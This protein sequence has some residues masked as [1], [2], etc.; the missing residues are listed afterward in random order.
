MQT[1]PHSPVG[2]GIEAGLREPSEALGHEEQHVVSNGLGSPDTRIEIG[3]ETKLAPRDTVLLGTDGLFDN[4]HVEGIVERIRRR[5][6]AQLMQQLR[7]DTA[8]RMYRRDDGQPWHCND[9]TFIVL[10]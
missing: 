3:P 10:R 7:S 9:L 2:Y 1:T 8:E 5:P 6:L 4:F